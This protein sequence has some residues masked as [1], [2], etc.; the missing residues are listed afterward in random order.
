MTKRPKRYTAEE[1]RLAA[2]VIETRA[3]DAFALD[4]GAMILQ[5]AEDADLLEQLAKWI[6]DPITHF[7]MGR[8]AASRVT[9]KGS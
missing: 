2:E 6:D 5:A 3:F 9:Q 4:L 1:L 7:A 8:L